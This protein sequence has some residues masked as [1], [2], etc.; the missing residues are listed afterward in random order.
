MDLKNDRE[1]EC[2]KEKLRVLE[3][4]FQQELQEPGNNAYAQ[5]LSLR[6]LS[7]TIKQFKEEI[8]RY[9]SRKKTASRH[10]VTHDA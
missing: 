4:C 1:L 2:T 3:E 10:V 6:S 7:R 5:E 9:E 8:I